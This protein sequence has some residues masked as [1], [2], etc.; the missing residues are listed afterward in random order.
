MRFFRS[1]LVFSLPNGGPISLVWGVSTIHTTFRNEL[2][3]FPVGYLHV[4]RQF[5]SYRTRRT[6]FSRA[7]FRRSIFLDV[8]IF[9]S[10]MA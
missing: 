8:Q 10:A 3:S 5:Y 9:F 2:D 4:L 6:R 7:Y 1:T